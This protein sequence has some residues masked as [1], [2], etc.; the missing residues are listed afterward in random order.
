[1][2]CHP[3]P[4]PSG[5]AGVRANQRGITCRDDAA[6]HA[7]D[8]EPVERGIRCDELAEYVAQLLPARMRRGSREHGLG[9]S[10]RTDPGRHGLCDVRADLI[11]LKREPPDVLLQHDLARKTTDPHRCRDGKRR[12]KRDDQPCRRRHQAAT[13]IQLPGNGWHRHLQ[14]ESRIKARRS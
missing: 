12:G 13:R 14:C 3:S 7:C 6:V 2:P 1:M 11:G 8:G 5:R 9:H 4:E 10:Q